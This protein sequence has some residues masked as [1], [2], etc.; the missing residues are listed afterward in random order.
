MDDNI[1]MCKKD[2]VISDMQS[3]KELGHLRVIASHEATR[4]YQR[5]QHSRYK[6]VF[7]SKP[8]YFESVSI[9]IWLRMKEDSYV[10][11]E[12]RCTKSHNLFKWYRIVFSAK[13]YMAS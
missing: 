11:T 5:Q 13:N 1:V 8:L 3:F 9:C 7:V 10:L 12:E 6:Q 2:V 4:G